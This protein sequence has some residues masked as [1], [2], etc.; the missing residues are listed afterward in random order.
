MTELPA[1]LRLAKE[2]DFRRP[3]AHLSEFTTQLIWPREQIINAESQFYTDPSIHDPFEL[4]EGYGLSIIA[5]IT[6]KGLEDYAIGVSD[7][8]RKIGVANM[9]PEQYAQHVTSQPYV[10]G[11]LTTR[12]NGHSQLFGYWEI[13]ARLPDAEGAWPALWLLPTHEQWPTGIAVLSE[14]DIMEGIAD[15]VNGVYH[16]SMHTNETGVMVHS[17]DNEV[18]TAEDLAGEFHRYG[19]LWDADYIVWYFDGVEVKCR[20]TPKDMLDTPRHLLMNLAVGGW[21]GQ[22]NLADYPASFDIEYVRIYTLPEPERKTGTDMSGDVVHVLSD[23][24]AVTTRDIELVGQ[25]LLEV[26]TEAKS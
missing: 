12:D 26:Q 15:V 25:Y 24:R 6:P 9:T 18:H 7:E 21:A 4:M 14:I 13:S 3:L 11:V 8:G 1:G 20:K 5:D 23:G 2:Y 10:S 17:A 22:P 19:L 16:A